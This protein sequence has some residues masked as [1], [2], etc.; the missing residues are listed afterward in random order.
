MSM[1]FQFAARYPLYI[2]NQAVQPTQWLDIDDK[3][4]GQMAA[5]VGLADAGLMEQAIAA[6][7]AAVVLGAAANVAAVVR[8][9]A[10]PIYAT[11]WKSA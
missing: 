8:C 9:I 1:P 4:T 11:T 3:Y 7:V 5:Q 6:A 2:A 10:A